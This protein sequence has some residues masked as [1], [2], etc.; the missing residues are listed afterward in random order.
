M[1]CDRVFAT[2]PK[3]KLIGG[4]FLSTA[5]SYQIHLN[6]RHLPTTTT[7]MILASIKAENE[8]FPTNGAIG[9]RTFIFNASGARF[10]FSTLSHS[11]LFLKRIFPRFPKS[12][13]HLRMESMSY[14]SE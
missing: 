3:K 7:M 13:V 2:L 10:R 1:Q 11:R 6:V 14:S 8:P 12:Q 9:C 5:E 4:L